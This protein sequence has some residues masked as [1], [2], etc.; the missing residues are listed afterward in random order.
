MPNGSR[1]WAFALFVA[2]IVVGGWG[3]HIPSRIRY[4]LFIG[5][6]LAALI[7]L[8]RGWSRTASTARELPLDSSQMIALTVVPNHV[9]AD[10]V[11]GMLQANG[12]ACRFRQT[13][14]AAGSMDGMPGGPQQIWVQ[15]SDADRAR[16]LLAGAR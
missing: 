8:F 14:F 12:V 15:E 3:S 9:E 5:F 10:L 2:A 4:V 16:H 11:C 13:D 1:G 6:M 7:A